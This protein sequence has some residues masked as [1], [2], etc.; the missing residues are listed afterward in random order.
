[1]LPFYQAEQG[2]RNEGARVANGAMHGPFEL[3]SHSRLLLS[4]RSGG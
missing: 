3:R 4:V 2:G 1:M